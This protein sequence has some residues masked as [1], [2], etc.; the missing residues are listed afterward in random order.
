M[1]EAYRRRRDT[2][3][4]VLRML[5]PAPAT[6]TTMQ[7]RARAGV[8]GESALRHLEALEAEGLVGR[9][10]GKPQRWYRR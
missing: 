6:L 10:A 8:S 9:I 5:R 2:R 7:I 3:G 4:V 1:G